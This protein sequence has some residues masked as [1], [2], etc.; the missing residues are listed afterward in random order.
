MSSNQI[1]ERGFAVILAMEF[2]PVVKEFL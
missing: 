2:F 1:G